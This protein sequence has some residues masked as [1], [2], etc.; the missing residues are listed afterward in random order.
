MKIV[1]KTKKKEKHVWC[2][3]VREIVN[4]NDRDF[5]IVN[6]CGFEVI[7]TRGFVIWEWEGRHIVLIVSFH[8][9]QLCQGWITL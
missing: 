9:E 2:D 7:L 3:E 6:E 8:L 5:N 4:V 1:L